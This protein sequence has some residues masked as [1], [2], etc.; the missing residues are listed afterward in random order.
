MFAR[1]LENAMSHVKTS[2]MLFCFLSG[3]SITRYAISAELA[4]DT[5]KALA[6]KHCSQC[7]TL[8]QGEGP[9]N[10]PNLFGIIGKQA[11]SAQGFTYSPGFLAVM[12]G[13]TWDPE[14][15]DRWLTDTQAL[16][17]GTGMVYFQDDPATRKK[18]IQFLQLQR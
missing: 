14:L 8:G 5:L 13:K 1:I 18:L 11:G 6:I 15:L 10:G 9:G 7:H 17:P 12:S 3:V 4:N 2:L 16:A